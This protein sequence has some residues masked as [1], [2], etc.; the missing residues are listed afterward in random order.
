MEERRPVLSLRER[1]RR[2][3]RVRDLMRA[4]QLECLLVGGYRGRERYES[5]ITDD[6]VEG[7]VVFPLEGEPTAL[8]WTG[9]RVSRAWESYRR[10]E[11][12]WVDDL[13]IGVSGGQLADV[14]REKGFDQSR[15]GVVGLDARSPT[16]PEGYLP[17]KVWNELVAALP[18]PAGCVGHGR[19]LASTLGASSE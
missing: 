19:A 14:I 3:A 13:R 5:Y 12:P 4:H 15:V 8:T 17:A 6:Y 7:A 16:E 1:D 2:W 10:G 9:L 18:S 11:T